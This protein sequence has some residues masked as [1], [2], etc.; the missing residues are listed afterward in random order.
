MVVYFF[1]KFFLKNQKKINICKNFLF[2][3]AVLAWGA[4]PANP[5][6]IHESINKNI[7][8]KLVKVIKNALMQPPKPP[9]YP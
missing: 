3:P 8:K 1:R 6:A 4:A 9:C 2:A 7:Y 5:P